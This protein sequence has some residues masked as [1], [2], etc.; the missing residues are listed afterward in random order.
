MDWPYADDKPAYGDFGP[1]MPPAPESPET[2]AIWDRICGKVFANLPPGKYVWS[3][4]PDGKTHLRL[5]DS[6]TTAR[7]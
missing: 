3:T 2:K 7:S 5:D 1:L 4:T 6:D